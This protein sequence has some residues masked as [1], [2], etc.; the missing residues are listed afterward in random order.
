LAAVATL[1][2]ISAPQA[3]VVATF[4][5]LILSLASLTST[6]SRLFSNPVGVYLGEVSFAVY[7]VTVPWKMLSNAVASKLLHIDSFP[8]PVW[9]AY[10][11]AVIPVAMVAHH[12]VERPARTAMRR[13]AE[14]RQN[15][16]PRTRY[17][18]GTAN[19]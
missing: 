4:G 19:A 1:V 11:A 5:G 14:R 3:L 9:L 16:Q 8:L 10:F 2:S 15:R 18:L 7:M 12:L 13:L 6:G 17:G